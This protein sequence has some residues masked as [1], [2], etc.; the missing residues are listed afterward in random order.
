MCSLKFPLTNRESLSLKDLDWLMSIK[1]TPECQKKCC[2]WQTTILLCQCFRV[3]GHPH[4][5]TSARV[6][7][8]S[9]PLSEN[10]PP[11]IRITALLEMLRIVRCD[12]YDGQ[13]EI[14]WPLPFR[15]RATAGDGRPEEKC[16]NFLN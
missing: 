3:H 7:I 2:F 6:Y 15:K 11:L 12:D 8:F 16:N 14:G 4:F 13:D 1:N 10:T 9:L 5:F